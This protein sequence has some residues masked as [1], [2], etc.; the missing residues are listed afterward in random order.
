MATWS[1]RKSIFLKLYDQ[2]AGRCQR[3][4]GGS[5]IRMFK[6]TGIRALKAILRWQSRSSE[7]A[8][9]INSPPS[10]RLWHMHR[11]D[12]ILGNGSNIIKKKA[13]G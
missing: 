11:D 3:R 9:E 1:F 7:E 12:G 13:R 5:A 4:C 2:E 10:R 8:K 6:N